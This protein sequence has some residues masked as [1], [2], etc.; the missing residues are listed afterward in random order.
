MANNALLTPSL[1]TK[2]TLVILQNNLVAA[3]KVNRKF[4]NQFTKIGSTLTI[5]KPN[6]FVAVNGPAL[7]LQDIQEPSTSITIS[8]QTH[9][10][11][12]FTQQDL[13]LTI[14]EFSERYLKPA[15]ETLANAIDYGVLQ[16]FSSV[17]NIVGTPGT[18][19]ASF[20][21]L[22][23]VGQRLDE[24]AVPQ[25]GRVLILNPAAYWSLATALTTLYV[26]SVA[27]PALKGFLAN[28][29]N[30]EIYMDQNVPVQTVG[31]LGGTPTVTGAGQTGSSLVTGGWSNSVTGLLNVGDVFTI[32][33]VFAINPQSRI[34]TG[35]LQNFV[36][37]ATASSNGSGA[38]TI[39]IYP[40]I[41]T[42]GPYQTVSA[43][44][45]NA[46]AITVKTGAAATSY[47]QN[48]AFVKDAFGLVVVPMELPSGVDFAAREM[49][50]NLSMTVVRAYDIN[51]TNFPCRMDILWG[52]ATYY[53]ELACRLTN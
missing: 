19:P 10:D 38:S 49:V 18:L 3:G 36:V 41:T 5:R 12:Q 33:G 31:A 42:T 2:E 26:K 46:A 9:V 1:I 24:G 40:A 25:D 22:A 48:L 30:F 52:T 35:T 6:K 43:S 50:K 23:A 17:Q 11:F 21:S 8:N 4:E 51:S 47:A 45:A 53:P 34:S 32:A 39:S 7:S 16:N 13:T 44:P 28:I 14:E 20:A 37:T 15:A 29:A 27:E